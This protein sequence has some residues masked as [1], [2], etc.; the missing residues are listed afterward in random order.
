MC[1]GLAQADHT[2]ASS[3]LSHTPALSSAQSLSCAC[4]LQL[5]QSRTSEPSVERMCAGELLWASPSFWG[6]C[7]LALLLGG[8]RRRLQGLG[9]AAA[10]GWACVQLCRLSL[11]TETRA[12]L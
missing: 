11:H 8:G 10:G 6:S 7:A 4:P 1:V 3:M 5:Q 12:L 2:L 9:S